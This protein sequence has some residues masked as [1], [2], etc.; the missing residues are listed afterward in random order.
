MEAINRIKEVSIKR[1]SRALV[2]RRVVQM[3]QVYYLVGVD[4]QLSKGR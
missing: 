4:N 1:E 3:E 2:E